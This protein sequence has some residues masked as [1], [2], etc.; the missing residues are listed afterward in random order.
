MLPS[1]ALMNCT[2]NWIKVSSI[3]RIDADLATVSRAILFVDVDHCFTLKQ[4]VRI[5]LKL[6]LLTKGSAS[7]AD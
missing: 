4:T 2:V 5:S 3:R 7:L 1:I 6:V